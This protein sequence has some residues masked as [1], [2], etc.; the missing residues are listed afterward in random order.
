[1]RIDHPQERIPLAPPERP[2]PRGPVATGGA[3]EVDVLTGFRLD[4][5]IAALAPVDNGLFM[6]RKLIEYLL[7]LIRRRII[8]PDRYKLRNQQR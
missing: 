6:P 1:M 3:E 2:L 4:A 8:G 7:L 5:G